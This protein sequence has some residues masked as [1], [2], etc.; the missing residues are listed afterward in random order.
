MSRF[1]LSRLPTSR[2]R[3]PLAAAAA[4]ATLALALA[5]ARA[6]VV[7]DWN[8]V[9]I[10]ASTAESPQA[11][12]RVLAMAHG[13]IFDAMNAIARG[14]KPYLI[15]PP[16]AAGAS[17]GAAAAT[18]A[19]GVLLALYPAQK[20][21]LDAAL[22]TSLAAVPEGAAKDDGATLGRLVAEKYIAARANDGADRKVDFTPGT[23][24]GQWRPAPP[25]MAPFAS[26][27][28]S[29]VTPF[30][31]TSALEVPAPGPLAIDSEA[32]AKEIDEVRRLGARNS[33]ERSADQTAAAIFSLIKGTELWS[34]AARA[35]AAAKGTTPI[36]NAR[37]FALM[38]MATMDA[39]VAGW[40]IKKQYPTWRPITAIREAG[41]R[42]DPNWEPL[43]LT[44]SHP[45]YVSGHCITSG[46]TA[47]A[48]ARLFGG[49]GVRFSATYGGP[50]GLSR[51]YSG[52]AQAENEIG[53]ARVWAGI[54]TR[55][56]DV[57][58]GIVGHQIADLVVERAMTPLGMVSAQTQ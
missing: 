13:A 35:S 30:V 33:T 39:S 28:W 3:H 17:Q 21:K 50:F 47:R 45:D 12:W 16:V 9:A 41:T 27:F 18:A 44:P 29:Q 2:F 19:H 26:V 51:S 8:Q 40:A 4:V 10:D 46:A 55:T 14:Y 49:D 5:P 34:A 56:A 7:T 6:D 53:D 23:K 57:H 52:F 42:P 54:H 24:P 48:L 20:G 22:K 32:Y 31:L 38:S 43:L 15:Q 58:G 1:P 37:I 11:S 25:S 36:E